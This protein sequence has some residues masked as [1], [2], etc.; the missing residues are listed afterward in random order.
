[1]SNKNNKNCPYCNH[2]T[3][4]HQRPALITHAHTSSSL[5][6]G[7]S[8][9]KEYTALAKE[10]GN[11]AICITDHGNPSSLMDFYRAAKKEGI[12]PILGLEFYLALDLDLKLPNKKRE[13]EFKD[14]H[15]TVY[16]QNQQG[17]KNFNKLTYLSFTEGYYYKP[18]INYEM[19]FEQQQGLIVTSGCAASMFNQ[20]CN[21]GKE[22]E[23]E[24]WFK[25]FVNTF[26][27]RFYGE[28]QFN[29]IYDKS[30][31][32]MDQKEMNAFIIKMCSKYDIPVLIGGDVHY[33]DPEDAKLQD[34]F[35]AC[36]RRKDGPA[37]EE[38]KESFI[39]A[40]NLF[41]HQTGDYYNFNK[42][43]D[44][45]YD[46]KF[47]TECLD[48]SL[49]LV[50][51]VSFEFET[52][53]T[54]FPKI[55]VPK[56]F[57]DSRE[58]ITTLAYDGLFEKLKRRIDRGEV[59]LKLKIDDYIKRL[60]YEIEVI[61]NKGV[62]D[63]FLIVYDLIRWVESEN[64]PR[65]PGRGSAAG[66]LLGY[67]LSI[68][69]VDPIKHNLLFERFLNKERQALA[70]IDS[71]FGE[72]SRGLIREYLKRTYGEESVIG[73][74]NSALYH[75]KSALQDVSRGL[76][77][78]TSF[79]S[80]LMKEISK[81]PD[82]EKQKN[83]RNY[84]DDLVKKDGITSTVR[85]W[86]TTNE[87]VI[88][89][90]D[91]M[92]GRLKNH[93]THAGGI[94]ITPGPVYDY[95]PVTR[96]GKEVVTAFR[97]SDGSSKDLSDLGLL[98]LDVLG[99][100]TL[101]VINDSVIQIKQQLQK[102]IKDDITYINL[103][104]PDLYQLVR[105]GRLYGVFQLSGG[106][107][108]LV[109]K[110]Q[111]AKF[112]D[113]VA[114]SS[115]NRPGPLETFGPIYAKW[116]KHFENGEEYRCEEDTEIYPRLDFMREITKHQ[117]NCMIHQED[118]MFMVSKAGGFNFGE[119]DNFRRAIAWR[120]DH[121]KYHTVKKYFDTLE[122]KMLEK[123]YSKDDVTY[124]VEYCRKFGGY[125]F[126]RSHSVCYAYI[127]MQC[128]YLKCYYPAYFYAN[129]ANVEK[130]EEYSNIV[131][132]AMSEGVTVL[133]PSIINSKFNWTVENE[134]KAIR[135]GLKAF[136]GLGEAVM[137]KFEGNVLNEKSTIFDVLDLGL[138]TAAL[139]MLSDIEAFKDLGLSGAQVLKVNEL[140]KDKKI[141]TWFTRK[142]NALTLK[143]MPNSLLQFPENILFS[144]VE[145]VKHCENPHKELIQKLVPYIEF[146]PLTDKQR[147]EREKKI[148]GFTLSTS[149]FLSEL[150]EIREASDGNLLSLSQIDNSEDAI[151]G[152]L[153]Q[154]V[155]VMKTKTGNQY[156]NVEICDEQTSIKA[157]MFGRDA[158]SR[159]PEVDKIFASNILKDKY[160]YTIKGRIMNLNP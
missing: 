104:N 114:V 55:V 42:I 36:Q 50:E 43:W 117:Y 49:K 129:T 94:L 110:I 5:L 24:E 32:G 115:L 144:I 155:S 89:W 156:L 159:P 107:L 23:A 125:S 98:K 83:L 105:D 90:A 40:R 97:E 133:P 92:L 91:K 47:I 29:E 67:A 8:L 85:N 154:K 158:I 140:F 136:K 16:I 123:G 4:I 143:T 79:E 93:G 7:V 69:T 14:K 57:K 122:E 82:L 150:K 74:S 109:D 72:G 62:I 113:V 84:F 101:N 17:Y 73:V 18:R 153:V 87:E 51:Q 102:D 80:V 152:W 12:K 11:P 22:R 116:K 137:K 65:G 56:E 130:H 20:L 120:E 76:G 141:N 70:D 157:K 21:I 86:I 54:H 13:V 27:D 1:M 142:H 52:D 88:H 60:D 146:T 71:D 31:F 38:K 39:H 121:P 108:P 132:T 126:N 99:V 106:A 81:L 139:T 19:L 3:C 34:I 119:A 44:Y 95:I 111:P 28:I 124:F 112:D 45:G 10:R 58:L 30:K 118:F 63:Y 6:D 64:I 26:G 160:G 100:K 148:L 138:N 77:L 61:A 151:Y 134:G 15:Q 78:D 46:D 37:D 145:E 33:A 25:R 35:I 59:G 2:P 135:I 41:Y 128:L 103:E 66:A 68:T 75:A 53:K 96:G 147:I 131:T 149:S 9:P 48:N 127:A